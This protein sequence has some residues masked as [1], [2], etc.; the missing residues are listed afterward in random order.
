[1]MRVSRIS[2][3]IFLLAAV[4][5]SGAGIQ[6][7]AAQDNQEPLPQET[8]QI[9]LSTDT[10]GIGADFAGQG[11]TIFGALGNLDPQVQRQGR[12][13]IIVV[14]EGPEKPMVVHRKGRV[15]GM[16]MNTSSHEF[17][18]VPESYIATATRAIQDVTDAKTFAKMSLGLQGLA[19]DA[20]PAATPGAQAFADALKEINE[21]NGRYSEGGGIVE[22]ISPNLFR[23][24]LALP[25]NIPVGKHKAR[26]FLFR[27]GA[28]LRESSSDLQ[29]QKA[30]VEQQIF[31]FAHRQSA[32]YGLLAIATAIAIGWLGKL[33]FSRD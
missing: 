3:P 30:G 25:A 29:I 28:F 9:G 31:T 20:N 6:V 19:F 16:W 2:L 14:L 17:E 11:L 10:V 13:D 4:L 5:F 7:S 33:I 8:M 12:Y 1:M 32:F 18:Q 22:F 27:N 23:A 21:K 15:M 24:T 26:A